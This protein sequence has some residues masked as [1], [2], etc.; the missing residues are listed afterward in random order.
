[1]KEVRITPKKREALEEM[2]LLTSED[3]LNYYPYRYDTM[4]FLDYDKWEV[5]CRVI[6]EGT[7]LTKPKIY[8]FGKN[9]S[10][11]S[12]ELGNDHDTYR[13]S[14]F[15]Q[16]WYLKQQPG[17]LMTVVGRYEGNRKILAIQAV[18][19]PM[20]TIL[21]IKPV[22]SLKDKLKPKYF[23]ELVGRVLEAN[24]DEIIDYVND[25]LKARYGFMNKY[26]ALK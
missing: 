11:I 21:G 20:I 4:E 19:Q 24:K 14:V 7:V 23:S 12:F 26:E 13:I 2:G 9:R 8:R 10:V 18:N 15:N 5:N 17:S 1:M 25:D 16:P 3:I 22:Y 6:M